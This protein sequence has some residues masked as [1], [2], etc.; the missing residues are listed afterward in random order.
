MLHACASN[1]DHIGII[2]TVYIYIY[3]YVVI[4]TQND[5]NFDKLS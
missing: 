5:S 2:Y 1:K 3:I 4:Q